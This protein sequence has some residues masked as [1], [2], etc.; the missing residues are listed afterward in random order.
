MGQ[1]SQIW[2]LT[3]ARSGSNNEAALE[4]L[5]AHC[6]ECDIA[7]MRTL[8]FPDD[9][10]PTAAELDAEG[11][12]RLGIFTGD[13][14]LNAA[15]TGLYGWGGEIMVLPGGTMNLLS[16]RLHGDNEMED[17]VRRIDSG[18]ARRVRPTVARCAKGDALAGLL[19]G[20][21]TAWA[22]VREAMRDFDIAE[23]AQGASEAMS[24]STDGAMVHLRVPERGRGEGYPLVEMTPSH[25]GIQIDGF[26]AE[27]AGQFLQQGF[28]LL[29][30]RFREGPHERLG[31]LDEIILE[32][33][34]ETSIGVLIDGEPAEVPCR[35]KF[36]VATCEVDLLATHHGF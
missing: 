36:E 19:A 15:I 12:K 7:V 34:D 4:K 18:A 13:G 29:R 11:I 10:L 2:L 14:T 28:A 22:N 32:S 5:L 8:R 33:E 35:A 21:G 1:K 30:R 24:K 23:I 9:D 25:R 6:D 20:P 27:D 17:I 31:L 3:N 26:Y 16:K